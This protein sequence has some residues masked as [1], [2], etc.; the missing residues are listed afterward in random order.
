M[1]SEH[2]SAFDRGRIPALHMWQVRE[3]LEVLLQMH[4]HNAECRKHLLQAGAPLDLLSSH[5][6]TSTQQTM[7]AYFVL[8]SNHYMSYDMWS[9]PRRFYELPAVENVFQQFSVHHF[10]E[11]TSFWS[12]QVQE[13]Y[14]H[15]ALINDRI[16]C[17]STRCNASKDLALFVVLCWWH[18]GQSWELVAADLKYQR[19]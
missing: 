7:D 11:L 6:W 16:I 9:R 18:I 1:V 13:I 2:D 3:G 17:P 15:L 12:V 8:L 4:Q 14:Q 10:Y 5:C 19:G